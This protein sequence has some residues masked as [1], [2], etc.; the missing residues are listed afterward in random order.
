MR[1]LGN[2]H[3]D[4]G[5]LYD[6]IL[7][8]VAGWASRKA[9]AR[10]ADRTEVG[11]FPDGMRIV[12]NGKCCLG[13]E[14]KPPQQGTILSYDYDADDYR[15]VLDNATN[16]DKPW[17]YLCAGGMEPSG[18]RQ[19]AGWAEEWFAARDARRRSASG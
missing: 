5:N 12:T 4:H 19:P 1:G 9:D 7:R 6:R 14:G 18:G 10:L 11:R 15:V 13:L 17:R 8:V 3:V 16:D 2:E